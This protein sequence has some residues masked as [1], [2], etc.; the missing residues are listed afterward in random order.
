MSRFDYN[1]PFTAPPQWPADIACRNTD[2]AVFFTGRGGRTEVARQVCRGCPAIELCAEWALEQ[3]ADLLHGVWGGLSR[4]ERR[5]IRAGR[6]QTGVS[7]G[8]RVA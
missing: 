6:R 4:D 3:S 5:A 1:D 2:T 7:A 8:Q